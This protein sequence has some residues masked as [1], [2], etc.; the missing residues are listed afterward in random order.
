MLVTV[1]EREGYRTVT[2]YNGTDA[3]STVA[4]MPV[5]LVLLDKLLPDADG[6]AICAQIKR[7]A[8][9][10]IPV[11]MVT[12]KASRTDRLEGLASGADDYLGKPFDLEELV[13][14]VRVMLRIKQAEEV[15]VRRN[16]E[17]ADIDRMKSQFIMTAGHEL[18]TP[19][20]VI[21]GLTNLVLRRDAFGF[22]KTT[23]EYYLRAI[24]SQVNSLSEL[25]DNILEIARLEARSIKMRPERFSIKDLIQ[26]Q[27]EWVSFQAAERHITLQGQHISPIDVW[28]DRQ[29]TEQ[30]LVNLLTNAIKY[31][32]DGSTVNISVRQHDNMAEIAVHDHGVGIAA[33]QMPLLFQRFSRLDNPRSVEAGGTGVGLYI[34]RSWVE[35]QGGRIW[36][37]SQPGQ[38]S[39]F[40][41]T[42]P[43]GGE[44]ATS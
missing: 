6:F 20:S 37:E 38:G 35:E 19:L 4:T 41:F 25:I 31:S 26:R 22:D 9:R 24:D 27:I 33:D 12:A 36:A 8:G 10:F 44:E 28:A 40:Y 2:A 13:A 30:I 7:T 16:E 17:L 18:R 34:A 42:L 21:K 23:E 15:L 32:Y 39:T 43:L 1:L 14:K 3:M 11:V 29:H 5:D